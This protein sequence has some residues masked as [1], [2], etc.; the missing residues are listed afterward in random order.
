MRR[1]LSRRPWPGGIEGLDWAGP[2]INSVIEVNPDAEAIAT[3]LDRER[4]EGQV[5]G[6]LH[7]IP[8]ML[9]DSIATDDRLQT[10]AGSLAL[11]RSRVPRDAGVVS[12]LRKVRRSFSAR[13]TCRTWSGNTSLG[14]A[15]CLIA[16]VRAARGG[17]HD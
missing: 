11:V 10:T 15:W 17:F 5:R 4:S 16:L 7:G 8:I 2:T 12:K 14:E 3:D 9:K 13:T 1:G 6:P